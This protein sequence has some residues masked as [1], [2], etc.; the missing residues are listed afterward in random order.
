M[1]APPLRRRKKNQGSA[2]YSEE[3]AEKEEEG[4]C[5]SHANESAKGPTPPTPSKEVPLGSPLGK[6]GGFNNIGRLLLLQKMR[7]VAFGESAAY[8][9]PLEHKREERGGLRRQAFCRWLQ[10]RKGRR[11]GKRK[12]RK[13]AFL[14]FFRGATRSNNGDYNAPSPPLKTLG[15]LSWTTS[16]FPLSSFF[17]FC[18]IRFTPLNWGFRSGLASVRIPNSG[19]E[20]PLHMHR[21]EQ[22]EIYGEKTP[23]FPNK[24]ENWEIKRKIFFSLNKEMIRFRGYSPL[25]SRSRRC[26]CC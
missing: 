25:A 18:E 26:S 17:F 2:Y 10:G 21:K 6:G 22:D 8:S 9:P 11:I 13:E 7:E 14:F 3:K 19:P 20:C 4:L 24:L 12:E 23:Q 5:R 15:R 16:I 1:K